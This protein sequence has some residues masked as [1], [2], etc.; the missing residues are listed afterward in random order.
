MP[1]ARLNPCLPL[2]SKPNSNSLC[3]SRYRRLALST[4]PCCLAYRSVLGLLLAPR[5][6]QVLSNLE[7]QSALFPLPWVFAAW[8]LFSLQSVFVRHLLS[9][10]H[11]Q[12]R[13]LGSK[14]TACL[15]P[16]WHLLI[17]N[18]LFTGLFVRDLFFSFTTVWM[19]PPQKKG[20]LVAFL[21]TVHSSPCPSLVY[22]ARGHGLESVWWCEYWLRI[23]HHV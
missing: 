5:L 17:F 6:G 18:S 13:P 7:R 2:L 12:A 9:T 11:K 22:H 4:S 1:P 8:I 21:K 23:L 20:N 19:L 14:S 15:F 16:S 10:Q 3:W